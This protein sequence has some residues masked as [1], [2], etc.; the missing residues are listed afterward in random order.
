MNGTGDIINNR[1]IIGQLEIFKD[2]IEPIVAARVSIG[3]PYVAIF[4]KIVNVCKF[5]KSKKQPPFIVL[6][7]EM[8]QKHF[9]IGKCPFRKVCILNIKLIKAFTIFFNNFLGSVQNDAI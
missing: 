3:N 2:I 8:F 6:L 7:L 5:L 4:N 1:T 9:G